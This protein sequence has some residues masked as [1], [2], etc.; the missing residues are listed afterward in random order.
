MAPHLSKELGQPVT[1]VNRKGGGTILGH[2]ITLQSPDDGY[3]VLA[4]AVSFMINFVALGRVDFDLKDF[5]YINTQW[6]DYGVVM[7]PKD[8]PYKTLGELI[9]AIKANPG[10]ISTAGITLSDSQV[11][12]AVLLDKLGLPFDAVR[13]VAYQGG[14]KMRSAIA[15]GQVDFAISGAQGSRSIQEFVR[16]LAIYRDTPGGIWDAPS[17]NAELKAFDAKVPYIPAQLRTFVTRASFKEKHPDRWA[18]LTAAF[19][20][21]LTNKDIVEELTKQGI[22]ADWLGPDKSKKAINDAADVMIP[23]VKKLADAK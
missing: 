8:R 20:A 2:Q 7:T 1:V 11:N 15:G 16:P 12:L 10:K 4:S 9:A 5:A 22:G 6:V 23:H 14:G 3:T 21:V 17:I 18:K 19:K 13:F